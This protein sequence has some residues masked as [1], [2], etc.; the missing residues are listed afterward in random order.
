MLFGVAL[1]AGCTASGGSTTSATSPA[2]A[3]EVSPNLATPS[4][5]VTLVDRGIKPTSG[6]T[7]D[8][9][10][11]GVDVR[12]SPGVDLTA[13]ELD[14][15]CSGFPRRATAA[16][17]AREPGHPAIVGVATYTDGTQPETGVACTGN[18]PTSSCVG[19]GAYPAF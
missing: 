18:G 4:S 9:F 12:C 13:A 15:G 11:L 5:E 2:V 10:K 17:D 8:G 14:R 3:A 19:I 7:I 16:L 6:D 1:L